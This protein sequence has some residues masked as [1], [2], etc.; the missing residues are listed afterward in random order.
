MIKNLGRISRNESEEIR[1]S[2]HEV[3][4][5][6][7]VKVQ[8]TCRPGRQGGAVLPEHQ[9]II[10]PLEALASLCRVLVKSQDRVLRDGLMQPPSPAA[11][12]SG[13]TGAPVAI[14]ESSKPA[15]RRYNLTEP[16]VPVRL[17]VECYFL[18][19]PD[20]EAEELSSPDSWTPDPAT[21]QVTGE[22][23]DV[24]SRGAQ[25]WL[26]EFFPPLSHLA[27]FMRIGKQVFRGRAEVV[28]AAS[29]P[30]EGQYR[31][32][33]RWLSLSDQASAALSK[34]TGSPP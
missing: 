26:A 29:Q 10:V 7:C 28:G 17:A 13:E 31:H 21:E 24:S 11:S 12:T 25:I 9:S 8:V 18:S 32:N 33:V 23:R 6:L 14:R 15:H 34:L 3:E 5:E 27:V 20:T 19:A 2:L 1:V 16:R 4:G 30:L 22:I